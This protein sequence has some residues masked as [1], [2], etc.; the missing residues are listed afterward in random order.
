MTRKHTAAVL[1]IVAVVVLM[2]GCPPKTKE[3][4]MTEYDL[5]ERVGSPPS[6][7]II[8]VEPAHLGATNLVWKRGTATFTA[9]S[10][11]TSIFDD[12]TLRADFIGR[13]LLAF[14]YRKK[15]DPTTHNAT[16][17]GL[18]KA[19]VKFTVTH[20]APFGAMWS[21]KSDSDPSKNC[22]QIFAGP[23]PAG[24]F[25]P[26]ELID[27]EADGFKHDDGSGEVDADYFGMQV[28][29]PPGP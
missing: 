28:E 25:L 27:L 24:D 8:I 4:C 10:P 21:A 1:V 16:K 6:T 12:C 13:A 17:I 29:M 11:P 3:E 20:N 22:P 23:I 15:S 7:P 18:K 9:S 19:G 26:E 2:A 14:E 5:V